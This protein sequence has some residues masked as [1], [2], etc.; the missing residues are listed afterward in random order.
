MSGQLPVVDS[1]HGGGAECQGGTIRQHSARVQ[2]LNGLYDRDG[3]VVWS[4]TLNRT[5]WY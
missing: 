5:L 2:P 4:L 3:V 1:A